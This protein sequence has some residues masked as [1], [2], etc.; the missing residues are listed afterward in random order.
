MIWYARHGYDQ[1]DIDARRDDQP[2]YGDKT[3]PTFE[4]MLVKLRR[5]IIA[6]RFS[7]ASAGQ[8]ADH[9]IRAVTAAWAAA[10]A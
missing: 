2:W 9:E 7:P 6:T 3:E 4:D 1:A 8:P 5:V 10:A